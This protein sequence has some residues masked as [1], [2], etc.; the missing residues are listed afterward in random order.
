MV[1]YESRVGWGCAG[2]ERERNHKEATTKT[3]LGG[4]RDAV[5]PNVWYNALLQRLSD[6][7][8]R[9][10]RAG[11]VDG[12]SSPAKGTGVDHFGPPGDEGNAEMGDGRNISR[13]S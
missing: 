7:L 5:S 2:I 10:N 4:P 9:T 13:F 12:L 8:I 3:F 6:K 1:A 11:R